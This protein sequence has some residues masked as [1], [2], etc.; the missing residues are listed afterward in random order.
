VDPTSTVFFATPGITPGA[1]GGNTLSNTGLPIASTN[2]GNTPPGQYIYS[3]G[4]SSVYNFNQDSLSFPSWTRYGVIMSGER[5][6][7][8]TENVRAY[9]DGS[10]Q[11]NM[12]ENQLAPAATGSFTTAGQTELVIPA[13]TAN[14]LPAADGRARAAIGGAYNPFNPFNMDITGGTRFRLKE[15]GNR[16]YHDTDEAFMASAGLRADNLAGKFNLDAGFRYSE[17]S[18]TG[19]DTLVSTSRF[20]RVLNANDPIFD[21]ASSQYIGTTQPYN[22]FGYYGNPIPNN[23][24]VVQF[25]IVHTHDYNVSS[26]GNAYATLNT[27]QMFD[28]P[29][30]AVGAALGA[31]YRVESLQQNPDAL[32]LAGDTI[33]SSAATITSHTRKVWAAFGE[34]HL[35]V[36]SPSQ[37][38]AGVHSLSVDLAARYESFV[39]NGDHTAVP[40]IALRYQPFDDSLTFRGSAARGF[41]EPSL[42]KL[43]SGPS[44]GLLTLVDPRDGSTLQETPTIEQGN[45]RLKAEKSKSYTLGVV[46]SPK[47]GFLKGFTTNLDLWRI[48]RRGQAL[49]NLQDTLD[50]YFGHAGNGTAKPGGL[51]T[52]EAVLFDAG[53]NIAQVVT[54]YLN[55]GDYMAQGVDIGASYVWSSDS[56][57]RFDVSTAASYLGNLQ[58]ATLPNT[59]MTELVGTNDT[60]DAEGNDAYV[61]LKGRAD[62]RWSRHRLSAGI[63]ANYLHHF[64]DY[65]FNG[66]RRQ[67]GGSVLWDAQLAYAIPA[68]AGGVLGST[69]FTMGVNNVFN[70]SP[71]MVQYYGANSTNY[72]GFLYSAEDRLVYFSIDRKF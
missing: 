38:I 6:L 55:A 2:N 45:S 41:L 43:Y 21:P 10:Y 72:P 25:A 64:I 59:P 56:L 65:D 63:S 68:S 11:Y 14:P 50:R 40:K 70:H 49:S 46:W 22:P 34:V 37:H 3:D 9:Y 20:N 39:T 15:F 47:A 1:S 32:N 4:R 23:A 28:L 33:G 53:G 26:L 30:G 13:R 29:G 8:G 71:P 35:P 16:I 54:N 48:E 12:T 31:D 52:G 66:N 69:K 58:L 57:G 18:Y 27:T 36:V 62:L 7:F 61:R 67:A 5:K 44:A 19:N 24:K 42:Y 17:I 60:P 51:Q